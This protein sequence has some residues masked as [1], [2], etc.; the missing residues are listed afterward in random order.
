MKNRLALLLFIIPTILLPNR[1]LYAASPTLKVSLAPDTPLFG[2]V[3]KNVFDVPF[4]KINFSAV[5]DDVVIETLVVRRGGGAAQDWAFDS[6][7][8]LDNNK[9]RIG[10]A[11]QL[12]NSV[13]TFD[14]AILVKADQTRS[15]YLAGNTH[16]S[17]DNFAGEVP[18]LILD[19]ITTKQDATI[20]AN[21]PVVGNYQTL[22]NTVVQTPDTQHI[23]GY[24]SFP[25]PQCPLETT[26]QPVFSTPSQTV[27]T[28]NTPNVI[29]STSAASNTPLANRLKGH[30][31][32][33]VE[34]SGEAWYVNPTD[35]KRYY[36]KDGATAYE[37]LRRFGL[38][39]TNRDLE[40]IPIGVVPGMADSNTK[41]ATFN[42]ALHS[43]TLINRLKGKILLQV[44]ALGEAWYVYPKD[45][46][47]YYMKD[48]ETAYQIMRS[49]SLGI[50]NQNLEGILAGTQL[51]PSSEPP[52]NRLIEP[53][54]QAKVRS[55]LNKNNAH[56][57]VV[58]ITCVNEYLDVIKGSGVIVSPDGKILT[59]AHVVNSS[60]YPFSRYDC[61][62]SIPTKDNIYK[63]D[64][65]FNIFIFHNNITNDLAFGIIQNKFQYERNIL[66]DNVIEKDNLDSRI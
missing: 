59:N 66:I 27:F 54:K 26:E 21:F 15:I 2:I 24:N 30:I 62:G 60:S 40:K 19:S 29:Q 25:L 47:R 61:I 48:G 51:Q 20:V 41:S 44:E 6:I 39:I 58:A 57:A 37:M 64:Y 49:L 65:F 14:T 56:K 35:I 45:G 53:T 17:L 43:Q 34:S 28:N 23:Y 16:Y 50:T 31:L 5:G 1:N 3:I 33:Q 10:I 46:R 8:L 7:T 22:N 63:P 55:E 13:V 52:D 36:M 11:K 18:T 12:V 4:T 42:R 38:G 32:L 9:C